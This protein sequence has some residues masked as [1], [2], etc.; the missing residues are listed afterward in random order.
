MR[1]NDLRHAALVLAAIAL[2][3]CARMQVSHYLPSGDGELRNRS[4][5]TFGLRDELES[6]LPGAVK[7]RI[8]GGDPETTALSARVQVLIPPQHNLRFTSPVFTLWS[9]AAAEPEQLL[10]TGIT[11]ACPSQSTNCQSRFAPTDWLEGGLI[12]SD[13]MLNTAL[14]KGPEPRTYRIDIA[15]PVAPGEPYT[16]KLPDLELNGRALQGPT[17]RFEKTQ[18]AAP[19]NLPVCQP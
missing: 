15:I 14:L 3:G 6:D 10:A 1:F 16:L 19:S 5:C 2:G 13:G 17:V 7:I 4:L 9:Q 8:W 12:E 18:A 11:S